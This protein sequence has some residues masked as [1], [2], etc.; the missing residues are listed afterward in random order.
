M[1][2][3]I[4]F[5]AWSIEDATIRKA[6]YDTVFRFSPQFF[7]LISPDT[8]GDVRRKILAAEPTLKTAYFFVVALSLNFDGLLSGDAWQWINTFKADF[9][10][11]C[12]ECQKQYHTGIADGVRLAARDLDQLREENDKLRARVKERPLALRSPISCHIGRVDSI[13]IPPCTIEARLT[14]DEIF[15]RSDGDAVLAAEARDLVEDVPASELQEIPQ[16]PF[17]QRRK[18]V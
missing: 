7:L 6:S 17:H 1:P 16:G 13:T 15:R 11:A 5:S 10:A 8:A 3:Y 18:V 2:A 14:D 9:G 4:V 12:S